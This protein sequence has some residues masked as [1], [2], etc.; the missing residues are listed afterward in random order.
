MGPQRPMK[1]INFSGLILA[2]WLTISHFK[3]YKIGLSEKIQHKVRGVYKKITVSN[4]QK[5]FKILLE[6]NGEN[7]LVQKVEK[8]GFFL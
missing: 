6:K 1:L 2:L 5:Y 4:S 8:E 3:G 7:V